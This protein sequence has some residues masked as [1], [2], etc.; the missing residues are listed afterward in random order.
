[1]AKNKIGLKFDDIEDMLKRL[2]RVEGDIKATTEA[3]LKASKQAVAP[4]IQREIA[5]HR[6]TGTTEATLDKDMS[7]KWEG[8]KGAIKIGF[9]I[10]KGG[11]P[12]IFLMYGTPRMKKDTKLYNSVYGAK[13]KKTIAA[14]QKEVFEKRITR[15]MG[16]G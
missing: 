8:T 14:A 10:R 11:L 1:M 5:R 2:E 4:G 13:T 16:G 3:A 7:V 9:N 6:R 15:R 12:S